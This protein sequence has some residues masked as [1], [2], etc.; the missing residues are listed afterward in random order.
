MLLRNPRVPLP[1][2]WGHWWVGGN[3]VANESPLAASQRGPLAAEPCVLARPH[4]AAI[5]HGHGVKQLDQRNVTRSAVR[6]GFETV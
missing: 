2:D 1:Q 5:L 3:V 4:A 6:A